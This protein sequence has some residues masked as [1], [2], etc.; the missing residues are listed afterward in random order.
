MKSCGEYLQEI[1]MLKKKEYL[2]GDTVAVL[3]TGGSLGI[4][5]LWTS[6]LWRTVDQKPNI[7]DKI[8]AFQI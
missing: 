4:T 1:P 5:G 8:P 3:L 2:Y 7:C 6:H